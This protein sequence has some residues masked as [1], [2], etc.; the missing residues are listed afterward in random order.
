MYGFS[1]Y[2]PLTEEEI[3]KRVSQEEIIKMALG[4]IPIPYQRI[5]NPMKKI[6]TVPG[7]WFEWWNGKLM[8]IDFGDNPT[9]RI[10]IKFIA[11]FY[12]ITFSEAL[13]LIN[14]HF[15]LGLGTQT[16]FSVPKPV[17]Y[18]N[19][20][21]HY[22][23]EKQ[24]HNII[25]KPRIFLE[26]DAQ[27]WKKFNISRNNLI[28]DKVSAVIWYKFYSNKQKQWMT[29]RPSDICYAYSEFGSH[30]KI[31]RPKSPTGKGKW[32]TNC[33]ENDIGALNSLKRSGNKLVIT[34]SYKDCRILRNI[35]LNSIWFQNEGCVP[36]EAIIIDLCER[37]DEIFFF[38]DNDNAGIEASLKLTSIFNSFYPSK[39]CSIHLPE[40]L[41]SF[42]IK[43][44]ANLVEKRGTQQIVNFAKDSNLYGK[45][46]I[47]NT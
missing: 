23:H 7:A 36:E 40:S 30:T 35:G 2:V 3:L 21:G 32:L 15:Q 8:F 1:N 27:Y 9:H 20:Q 33:D 16:E 31:Y 19:G 28:E 47:Y 11:D 46:T 6:D 10:T 25:F 39:S 24:K 45:D 29:I 18:V 37:F 26:Q 38:Y 17:K 42:N 14:S 41:L 4:H 44:S 34:K 43:D 12:R 22:D 5:Y 13:K